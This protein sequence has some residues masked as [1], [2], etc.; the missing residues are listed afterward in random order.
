MEFCIEH[1]PKWVPLSVAVGNAGE[2]GFNCYEQ[3]GLWLANEIA[4][5]DELLRRGRFG[6]DDFAHSLGTVT[7]DSLSD[8]FENIC[9][10]RAARRMWYKLLKERYHAKKESSFI[11]RIH[12]GGGGSWMTYQEP[13]NNIARQTM[14]AIA[15]ALGGCQSLQLACY[16]E[17]ICIPSEQA[18]LLAVRTQQIAQHEFGITNVADP[19]GG[20]YFIEWLTNEIETRGWQYLQKI[21]NQ[22]GFIAALDSGWLHREL[23]QRMLER[24]KRIES[25]EQK[26][27][28]VNCFQREKEP[29]QVKTF[30]VT[31][32]SWENAIE[33]LQKVRAERDSR[34]V[35]EV[36]A[37]LSEV[38]RSDQ[39]IM[40]VMMKAVKAY[41]TIGEVGKIFREVFSKWRIPM[42][43]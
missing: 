33:R 12:T 17:A 26:V 15:G 22:G 1:V 29:Y 25:G 28:G 13:L 36:L 40:P 4:Y 37:E 10:L 5:I 16:D 41:V 31:P 18:H 32:R 7:I 21:E 39:G 38:C 3:L 23:M 9:A 6:I 24:Q 27:V 35:A 30:R 14:N 34:L 8:F 43:I 20:S 2:S 11:L 19:L 42:P